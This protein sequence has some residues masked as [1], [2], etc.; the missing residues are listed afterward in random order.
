[1]LPR[2]SKTTED[3]LQN[4][5]ISYQLRKKSTNLLLGAAGCFRF[6]RGSLVLTFFVWKKKSQNQRSDLIPAA[7]GGFAPS[8]LRLWIRGPKR[9]V[10][11]ENKAGSN[12]FQGFIG[13]EEKA[14]AVVCL[15]FS[16]LLFISDCYGISVYCCL[17]L[18][19][20]CSWPKELL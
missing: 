6:I 17:P 11:W 13:Q 8:D 9:R 18:W 19:L 3:S 16:C 20:G 2:S 5:R 15:N 12:G 14:L 7:L 4:A 1:M 10:C